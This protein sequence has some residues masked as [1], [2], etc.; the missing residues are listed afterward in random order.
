MRRRKSALNDLFDVAALLP[1]WASLGLAVA[2]W[3]F[4]SWYAGREIV[5]DPSVPFDAAP[6]ILWRGFAQVGQF[7]LPV[8]L[9]LGTGA[10]LLKRFRAGK[11]LDRLGGAS[12]V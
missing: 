8:V 11:M 10:N 5:T 9:L 7:V 12:P 2:S 4:L 6:Q 1:W 3:V